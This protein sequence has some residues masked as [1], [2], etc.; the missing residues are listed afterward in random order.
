[1][2]NPHRLLCL[3]IIISSIAKSMIGAERTLTISPILVIL[4]T[5]HSGGDLHYL[6]YMCTRVMLYTYFVYVHYIPWSWSWP[7]DAVVT[8]NGL[9]TLLSEKESHC[10]AIFS[11]VADILN[12]CMECVHSN[13]HPTLK[14]NP[15]VNKKAFFHTWYLSIFGCWTFSSAL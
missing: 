6:I 10:K 12:I 2:L 8:H 5:V 15:I 9:V 1:M 14:G 3:V 4:C 11:Y 7:P 13:I